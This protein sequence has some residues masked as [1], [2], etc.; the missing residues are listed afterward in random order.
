MHTSMRYPALKQGPTG[1]HFFS[2]SAAPDR[3]RSVRGLVHGHAAP[4]TRKQQTKRDPGHGRG[5][6]TSPRLA[7]IK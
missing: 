2:D 1:H 5:G 6:G 4:A 3:Y 7:S